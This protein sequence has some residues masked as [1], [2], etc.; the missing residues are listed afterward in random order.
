MAVGELV[1]RRVRRVDRG[2]AGRGRGGHGDRAQRAL[3]D[4]AG[5]AA[6]GDH[7]GLDELA[8]AERLEDPE[9]VGELGGVA[10]HLD[11]DRVGGDVDDLGAEQLDDVEDLAAGLGG[12]PRP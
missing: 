12:R 9:H 11:G 4:R 10:G 3:G 2:S 8:D 7:A 6:D 5:A 1:R